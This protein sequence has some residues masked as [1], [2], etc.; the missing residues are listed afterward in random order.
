MVL[1]AALIGGVIGGAFAICV[2][3]LIAVANDERDRG[4]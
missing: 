2:F 4:K 1:S 3:A